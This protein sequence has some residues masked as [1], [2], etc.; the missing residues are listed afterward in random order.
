MTRDLRSQTATDAPRRPAEARLA[1]AFVAADAPAD[2]PGSIPR[3][4][5]G[6]RHPL[7]PVTEYA[8]LPPRARPA[9]YCPACLERVTLRLGRRNRHH[10]GHRP[11]S[12][13]AAAGGE[14][15]LHLAAKV[16]LASV[17]RGAAGALRI[18][19]VCARVPEER[20]AERCE[21]AL[22]E[23]WQVAWDD[24]A[25]EYALPSARADLMLLR[26][27]REV[28]ALEV[29]ASHAVDADKAAKYRD[30]GIPWIEVP[31]HGVLPEGGVAWTPAEP[32]PVL[33]DSALAPERWRCPRHEGLYRG[34][35][36]H[37]R[38]GTHL[39]AGR[40]VHLY[41]ADGGR[42]TGEPR[43]RAVV[44]HMMERR[45]EGRTVEAWLERSDTHGRLGAP[46]RARD[47]ADAR[48]RLHRAFAGWARWMREK[49]GTVVDSP[50]R[51]APP[52]ALEGWSR[53]DA[54]PQRLRWDVHAGRF[55]GAPN[56]APIAWP[57]VPPRDPDAPDAVL[58]Y[59]SC[60]WTERHPPRLPSLH[61]IHGTVWA[62]LR[63]QGRT[64]GG[65]VAHLAA[66][67]HDG[68][69]WRTLAGAPYLATLAA[70]GPE[71]WTAL[72]AE[73]ARTLAERPAEALLAAPTCAFAVPAG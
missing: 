47:A 42:S 62:T 34:A 10:Y 17:L 51:W 8:H 64:R 30:R 69:R 72:L 65:E 26:E 28:A 57:R 46:V 18:R 3:E 68:A 29:H 4:E 52:R 55:A 49:N 32:L 5:A 25:L 61:A 58:G 41:R 60:A 6:T 7:V 48:R 20:S 27:G 9:A 45:E 13:C 54:Y 19:R 70:P 39:L 2:A 23:P 21:R 53:S 35:L 73:F 59:P 22:P 67:L 66:H 11:G 50:M 71:A 36:E 16:H 12:A 44:V 37:A 15:A 38:S 1:W 56:I 33:Q 40:V 31:A 14:G 43:T 63:V 24:V